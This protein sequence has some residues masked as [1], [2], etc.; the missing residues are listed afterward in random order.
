MQEIIG[1]ILGA[2]VAITIIYLAIYTFKVIVFAIKCKFPKTYE[3]KEGRFKAKATLMPSNE[4][5]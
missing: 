3:Y 5:W 4:R 2:M 1:M